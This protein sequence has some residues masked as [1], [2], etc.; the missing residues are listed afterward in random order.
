[1]ASQTSALGKFYIQQI[2]R[3]KYAAIN[4][5]EGEIK[6]LSGENIAGYDG[7]T[8]KLSVASSG[9]DFDL[10]EDHFK[11]ISILISASTGGSQQFVTYRGR[12]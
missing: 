6:T 9:N 12:Y 3:Q 11:K 1:M 10:P 7:F 8:V 5:Y 4:D 2:H